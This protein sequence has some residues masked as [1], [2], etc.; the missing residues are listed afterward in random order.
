LA[1]LVRVAGLHVFSFVVRFIQHIILN[2]EWVSSLIKNSAAEFLY[3]V[4]IYFRWRFSTYSGV[5]LWG[6]C[7]GWVG[8]DYLMNNC[9]FK[10]QNL[11][12]SS[13]A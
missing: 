7:N 11:S 13:S 2:I 6:Y 5:K 3:R 4:L 10:R 1:S 12:R 8:M 9:R